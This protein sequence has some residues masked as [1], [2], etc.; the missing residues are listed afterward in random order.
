MKTII[1]LR[2]SLTS[3]HIYTVTHACFYILFLLIVLYVPLPQ[4]P[5]LMPS[6]GDEI[7]LESFCFDPTSTGLI[8]T[9][10]IF[11][12]AYCKHVSDLLCLQSFNSD[13]TFLLEL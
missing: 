3:R 12:G 10:I 5:S 2:V 11:H 7:L 1:N 6:K 13:S 8:H 9:L 4:F